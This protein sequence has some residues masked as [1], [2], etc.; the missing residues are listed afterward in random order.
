MYETVYAEI[1]VLC[2]GIL[3]II[4]LRIRSDISKRTENVAFRRVVLATMLIL[5]LDATWVLTDGRPSRVSNLI[6]V[7]ANAAYLFLSCLISVLWLFYV[8]CR[9]NRQRA[10]SRKA[11][12]LVLAPLAVLLL[13]CIS[14]P[15]TGFLFTIGEDNVYRRGDFHFVQVLIAYGYILAATVRIVISMMRE[16][17]KHRRIEYLPLLSFALPPAAGGILS[18]LVF[19]VPMIWPAATLSILMVFV[20]SQSYQ[21]STDDLTGL[22]NRRQFDRYLRLAAQ[23]VRRDEVLYLFLMDVN[24]FKHINDTYGHP[25]GDKALQRTAR[26]L[27]RVCCGREAFL[28]RYGGDEF[29]IIERFQSVAGAE[30]LKK[31]IQAAFEQDGKTGESPY[32]LSMSVGHAAQEASEGSSVSRL[33]ARAD[34]ALYAEKKNMPRAAGGRS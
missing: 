8:E 25:E 20:Q 29:A 13:L 1:N 33:I 9:L 21:I 31:S 23:E 19:G 24:A 3:L 7:C 11:M 30:K 5:L 15:W 16:L 14:S 22:N 34:Q 12:L 17:E 18:E 32:T 2:I 27:R 26:V 6:N 28:A 4:W 10:F